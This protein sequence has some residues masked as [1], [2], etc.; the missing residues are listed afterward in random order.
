MSGTTF[1]SL[2]QAAS[3][4]VEHLI[5]IVSCH[6]TRLEVLDAL[7]AELLL[8]IIHTS[9]VLPQLKTNYSQI[10]FVAHNHHA[11]IRSTEVLSVF[12]PLAH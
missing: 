5:H 1:D 2:Q 4:A 3:Q 12:D 8:C 7:P 9:L 11:D 6:G 10:S